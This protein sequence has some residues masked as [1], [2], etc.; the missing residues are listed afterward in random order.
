M[1]LLEFIKSIIKSQT[2]KHYKIIHIQLNFLTDTL[3]TVLTFNSCTKC[4]G[5]PEIIHDR[6]PDRHLVFWAWMTPQ[7]NVALDS[8]ST[9]VIDVLGLCFDMLS[10]VVC[11]TRHWQTP[12][13]L[14]QE[15]NV[16][17]VH[18]KHCRCLI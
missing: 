3:L 18:I 4:V 13:R 7:L 12:G 11:T 15:L 16:C 5:S 17:T 1:L 6:M 9:W 14:V 2:D 8:H 10:M